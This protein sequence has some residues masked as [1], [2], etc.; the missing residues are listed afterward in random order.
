MLKVIL[1][2]VVALNL[3]L[4]FSAVSWADE[5][6]DKIR[7]AMRLIVPNAEPDS[8]SP[9]QVTG[10]YEV[11]YGI[12]VFYVS[13]DSRYL[14]HGNIVDLKTGENLAENKR[15]EGR[16]AILSKVDESEM[17]V[18]SPEKVKHTITVFTDID[19]TYCRRLH[20]EMEVLNEKGI[21]IR[22]MFFP[23]AGLQS[24]AYN[25]AVSVWCAKD[26]KQALTE[27]K[28]GKTLAKEQCDN[29]V[30]KHMAIVDQLGLTGTPALILSDGQIISGYVP[31]DRLE[32]MLE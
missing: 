27:A 10:F 19:C 5:V 24:K 31:A 16:L 21:E 8:I 30:K 1:S 23:R 3:F 12:E 22:Y 26:R 29:P 6:S 13:N 25:K 18:F 15:A 20:R 7:Q 4:G 14:M 2:M 28:A 11:V 9:S 32:Q 17:I